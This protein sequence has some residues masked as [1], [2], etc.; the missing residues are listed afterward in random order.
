L[1]R[2]A[3]LLSRSLTRRSP[4]EAAKRITI[5]PVQQPSSAVKITTALA[6][7]V[8]AAGAAAGEVVAAA[9]LTDLSLEQLTKVEVT[10]VS[11][12]PQSLRSAAA[13][14]YVITA[15]EIRRSAATSLPEAL[16]LAPNLQVAR[17]NSGQYAISARGF[18]NAIANKLLVLI[19][20]RT[21]YSTLFSGVFWDF[22]DLMLDDIDRIEVISGPGGTIWGANAVDGVIN[23]VTRPAADTQGPRVTATRSGAGGNESARWGGKVGDAHVR[24]YGM[25]IDRDNTETAAGAQRSDASSK[26][27]AGFRADLDGGVHRLSLEGDAFTGGDLPSTNLAPKMHGG[28]LLARWDSRLADGSP[29]RVQASYDVYARDETATFRNREQTFDLQFTHEPL[30]RAG[31]QVL[32]GAGYR[33]GR[34]TNDPS[35]LLAFIPADRTLAWWNLFVQDQ[36]ALGERVQLTVGAKGEH[37]SY[38]GLEFLPELRVAYSHASGATT[39]AALSRAVRAP[40]RIDRDFFIPSH[41]PYAIAGGPRFQSEVANVLEGGHRGNFGD[42]LSYDATIFRQQYRGLRGGDGTLPTTVQNLIDGHVDGVEAW[43]KWQARPGWRLSAGFLKLRKALH[44]AGAAP[45]AAAAASSIANL[46]NDPEQQWKLGSQLDLGS[47]AALDLTVRRV[48]ALPAPAVP[49]YTAVD[50]RLAWSVRPDLE[51]SLLAQNLFDAGH[52]EFNAPASAS[53]I[54]RQIF[55]RAVWER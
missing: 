52:V 38:T 10:S 49:A 55:L 34:D 48:G 22:H 40:S 45:S 50:A 46:G 15:E 29:Y 53:V 44:Y 8:F 19:D 9:N 11:G 42:R 27:Q 28:D 5:A 39:W 30:V 12:R 17:L 6:T 31:H 7:L 21:I 18:N 13:S 23:I 16:R 1:R 41:P 47:R 36:I 3:C 33:S 24:L 2:R 54:R 4:T 35:P 43:A 26:R 25:A 20:G 14:I 32:W 37:N 51:I